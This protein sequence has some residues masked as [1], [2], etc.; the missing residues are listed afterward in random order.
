MGQL[1]S[2]AS[3]GSTRIPLFPGFMRSGM[4]PPVEPMT[5][6]P[7][8][9]APMS[10]RHLEAFQVLLSLEHRDPGNGG[11]R[12]EGSGSILREALK[13]EVGGEAAKG[14]APVAFLTS[15]RVKLV[16]V[17]VPSARRSAAQATQSANAATTRLKE[18]P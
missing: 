13:A 2:S 9:N 3:S 8:T 7:L 4:P 18:D 1:Q 6:R 12:R 11:A 15:S 17:L 16:R 10:T 5:G 14:L